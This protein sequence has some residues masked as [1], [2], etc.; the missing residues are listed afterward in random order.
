MK[1]AANVFHIIITLY[2]SLGNP[3]EINKRILIGSSNEIGHAAEYWNGLN[4]GVFY[5]QYGACHYYQWLL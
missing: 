1:I 4:H 2:F 5:M 3:A